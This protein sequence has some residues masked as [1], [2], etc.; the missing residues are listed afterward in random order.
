MIIHVQNNKFC[1]DEMLA[2]PAARIDDGLLDMFFIPKLGKAALL[3]LLKKVQKGGHMS[4]PRVVWRRFSKLRV[5]PLGGAPQ[6][7]NVDGDSVGTDPLLISVLP[8]AW[9][10]II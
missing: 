10:F 8:R 5:E 3:G 7:V 1:G 6:A 4:D 2:A 9:E